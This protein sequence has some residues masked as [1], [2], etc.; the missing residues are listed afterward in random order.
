MR[1]V[2]ATFTAS[3]VE[4]FQEVFNSKAQDLVG[5]LKMEVGKGPFDVLPLLSFMTL[6][7]ICREYRYMCPAIMLS[8]ELG[9]VVDIS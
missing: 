6:R 9:N 5:S 3:M 8:L 2:A 4:G 1:K 7:A